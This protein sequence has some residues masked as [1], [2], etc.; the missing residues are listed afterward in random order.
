MSTDVHAI[1]VEQLV[2]KIGSGYHDMAEDILAALAAHGVKV[3]AAEN[4][5]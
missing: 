1:I 5:S 3:I 4:A 2:R